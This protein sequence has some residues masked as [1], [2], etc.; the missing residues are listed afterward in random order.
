MS[1]DFGTLNVRRGERS[2]EIE[3]LRGHYLRHREALVAMIEDS[4]TE[5]LA[6]EYQKIVVE[7][8]RSLTKLDELEGVT[9]A[10]R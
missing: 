1:D 3:I 2:R 4:P 7:L 5:H 9:P 6:H 8:D 10:A